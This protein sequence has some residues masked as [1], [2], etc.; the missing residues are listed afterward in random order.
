MAFR[1]SSGLARVRGSLPP[2]PM[3]LGRF[4]EWGAGIALRAGLHPIKLKYRYGSGRVPSMLSIKYEGP[5]ID[6]QSIPD[7]VLY[8]CD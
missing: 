1:P 7:Q 2:T 8:H 4:K 3:G 6:K 5:G